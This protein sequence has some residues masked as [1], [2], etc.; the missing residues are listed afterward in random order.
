[1]NSLLE[2]ER[3]AYFR[4]LLDGH[5]VQVRYHEKTVDHPARDK[6]NV[7]ND[8]APLLEVTFDQVRKSDSMHRYCEEIAQL[9]NISAPGTLNMMFD[10]RAMYKSVNLNGYSTVVRLFLTNDADNPVRTG[11]GAYT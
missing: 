9:V 11:R 2:V 10:R 8:Q 5:G 6:F 4:D 1:M 7:F 3:N